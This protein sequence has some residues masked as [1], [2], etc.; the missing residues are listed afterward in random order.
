MAN[1]LQTLWSAQAEWYARKFF[2][3]TA[4]VNNTQTQAGV[5][6]YRIASRL[7]QLPS[8]D[9]FT[10]FSLQNPDGSFREIADGEPAD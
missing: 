1:G 2:G 4:R 3:S 10:Q 6:T 8:D 5:E 9:L 7:L